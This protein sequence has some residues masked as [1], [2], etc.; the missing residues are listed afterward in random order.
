M[1]FHNRKLNFDEMK[2]WEKPEYIMFLSIFLQLER[3]NIAHVREDEKRGWFSP[4]VANFSLSLS[5]HLLPISGPALDMN[6]NCTMYRRM[7]KVSAS[8]LTVFWQLSMYQFFFSSDQWNPF[9]R[10][11]L[12]SKLASRLVLSFRYFE[13][14]PRLI[15]RSATSILRAKD[16]YKSQRDI[17]YV[18][19][20]RCEKK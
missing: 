6:S 17:L 16:R 13:M 8:T 18:R 7:M 11:T 15:K 9:F 12:L 14:I 19:L 5:L 3:F 2:F 1:L 4:E 10:A 20:N